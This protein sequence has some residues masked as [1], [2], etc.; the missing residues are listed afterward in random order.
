MDL[1]LPDQ[2]LTGKHA[3]PATAAE[4]LEALFSG[5]VRGAGPKRVTVVLVDEM[6]L[7]ITKKQQARILTATFCTSSCCFVLCPCAADE[8]QHG[9][10]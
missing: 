3:S 5:G 4:Q 9:R 6:D 7:L 2:A 10:S 8:A 1:R